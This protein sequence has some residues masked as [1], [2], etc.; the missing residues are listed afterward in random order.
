MTPGN[1]SPLSDLEFFPPFDGFPREGI[2]FL[3]RLKRNNNRP[4]FEKHKQEY[5]S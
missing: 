2:G 1:K 5:E 4:W 3:K